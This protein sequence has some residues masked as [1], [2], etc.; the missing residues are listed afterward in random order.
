VPLLVH[1]GCSG[2]GT[3]TGD[4]QPDE[5]ELGQQRASFCG[6]L[7]L[8]GSLCILVANQ[9]IKTLFIVMLKAFT[10]QRQMVGYKRVLVVWNLTSTPKI[11]YLQDCALGHGI[12]RLHVRSDGSVSHRPSHTHSNHTCIYVQSLRDDV[13]A[14]SAAAVRVGPRMNNHQ[15]ISKKNSPET[16]VP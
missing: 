3:T 1:L 6:R 12:E 11:T 14:A 10:K 5:P 8:C 2:L 15:Y 13:E 16:S 7:I 4:G 9:K